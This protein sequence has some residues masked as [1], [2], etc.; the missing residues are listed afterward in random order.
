MSGRGEPQ[1]SSRPLYFCP[2][3]FVVSYFCPQ[4]FV[5]SKAK[6]VRERTA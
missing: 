1:S 5:V 3:H 6:S 4:H 2:Q